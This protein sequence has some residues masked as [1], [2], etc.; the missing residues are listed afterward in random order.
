MHSEFPV[1]FEIPVK[2]WKPVFFKN[3]EEINLKILKI[4][5][6]IQLSQIAQWGFAVVSN[7]ILEIAGIPN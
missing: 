1:F 2:S 5:K 4:K 7:Y 6:N 3:F